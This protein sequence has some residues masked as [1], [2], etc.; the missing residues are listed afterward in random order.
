MPLTS[1]SWDAWAIWLFKA[2]AFF[3]DGSIGPYLDRGAEFAN[4]P[5]Y[6][7]LVPLYGAFVYVM[8]S[9]VADEAAKFLSPCFYAAT[10]GVFYHFARRAGSP[11]AATAFTLM[12]AVTPVIGIVAFTLAG[13]AD[14]T[15]SLYLLAAGGFLWAWHRDGQVADLAG[16]S[17]A[18]T[19]A[20]W[21]KNEGQ[22]FLLGVVLLAGFPIIKSRGSSPAWGWL[23]GPPAL[24]LV[25]WAIVRQSHGIEAAEFVPGLAFDPS[26]CWIALRTLAAKAFSL[27]LFS[28]TFVVFAASIAAAV[29]LNL[30][31]A[32]WVL[33][34]LV[35]WHLAGS[36]LAYATGRNDID[37]WL[38]TSGDRILAQI[39][40]LALLC[41]AF[42]FSRWFALAEPASAT[43]LNQAGKTTG[44]GSRQK[45]QKRRA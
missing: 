17:I 43:A 34:G 40:P 7:L 16:A 42:V 5:G 32:F 10:L 12:L 23:L 44:A 35:L 11:L 31:R 6:P 37:W 27:D 22:F 15:L 33:P 28:L 9:G 30:A 29:K 14:T 4:H 19:A 20:A 41:G 13:Y 25:P 38:A 8:R 39:A 21:T 26:L 45:K 18:A 24:V 3:L 2:K 36:L 1:Q